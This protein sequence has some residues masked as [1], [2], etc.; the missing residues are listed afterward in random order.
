MGLKISFFGSSLISSY[1]NG[2][3][4][5]FRGII[6]ALNQNGH[7]ITFYEPDVHKRK[8]YTDIVEPAWAKS[9]IYQPKKPAL[10]EALKK[11]ADADVII[12]TSGV[13][14]F[15]KDLEKGIIQNRKAGQTIIFWDGDPQATINRFKKNSADPLIDLI[16]EYDLIFTYGGGEQVASTYKSFGAKNCRPIYNAVDPEIH[17]PAL[18]DSTFDCD[19][20]FLG[21]R[22]PD[23][24]VRVDDF[25]FHAASLL[26]D[27]SFLI[28]GNGWEQKITRKNIRYSGHV[29][30]NAHNI[31]NSTPLTVLNICCE[32]VARLGFSP[33]TRIFEAAGAGACIITDAWEGIEMFFEPGKEILIAE[34]GREVAAILDG[35]APA[36]AKRIGQAALKRVLAE[37]TYEQR[38]KEVENALKLRMVFRVLTGKQKR[39]SMHRII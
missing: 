37:H 5:Y 6:K 20:A 11:G 33:A 9:V 14:I 34:N 26:P 38:A 3:A 18:P 16:P 35:L 24:E 4:T 1:W 28:A 23:R 15:D 17:F 10:F 19:L 8:D 12:K 32:G 7:Q 39:E 29:H 27:K 2:T 30:I 31:F 22:H 25:F 21:N 36:D 13:G